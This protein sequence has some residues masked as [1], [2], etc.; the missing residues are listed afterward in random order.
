MLYLTPA[1]LQARVATELGA[2]ALDAV[3]AE[4]SALIT[5]RL[6][7]EPT[8]PV[9]Q[10]Y[11]TPGAAL[12]LTYWPDPGR[13]LEVRDLATDTVVPAGTYR[14]HGR[15]L[16]GVWP[17]KVR[18]TY[19]LRRREQLLALLRGVCLD[20]C[21]LAIDNMGGLQ[22]DKLGD[23]SRTAADLGAEQRKVLARLSMA[24]PPRAVIAE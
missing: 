14:L 18:V 22:S 5:E 12:P 20:L 8:E 16:R 10:E 9:V 11:V 4:A 7:A 21:R 17:P 19:S 3:I 1:E 15:T 23:Y 24:V 6:G 2:E 13:P